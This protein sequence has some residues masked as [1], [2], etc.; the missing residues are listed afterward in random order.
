MTAKSSYEAKLSTFLLLAG[1]ILLANP[2]WGV[3]DLLPDLLAWV[4]IW[5]GLRSLSELNDELFLAR[6]QALYLMAIQLAK[7]LLWSPLQS[8]EIPSDTMLAV[9]VATVG[10]IWCGTLFFSRLFR[11]GDEISRAA[12][13]DALYLKT[14][15]VKFLSCMFLWVRGICTLLPQLTAIP[16]WLVQY[17]EI[18]DDDL[19]MLCMELAAATDLLNLLLS[20]FVIIA[21]VVWLVSYLPFLKKLMHE[22][23]PTGALSDSITAEDPIRLLKRRFS[24]LHMARIFFAIGLLFL[25]DLHVDGFRFMPLCGFPLCFA[26]G[27]L[28]LNGFGKEKRF[29][30]AAKLFA[31]GFVW[32]LLA[33]LYRRYF[34]IWDLRAFGEVDIATELI[35]A[36]IMLAGTC[37]LFYAWLVFSG[38]VEEL[39]ASVRCGNVYLG[40]ATY[41][42][43]V[44]YAAVQT[45]I[46][47]L[48]LAA[49]E[50]NSSRIL[51]VVLIW[52]FTNRRL[53]AFEEN[54][55]KQMMLYAGEEQ[56]E[57][58]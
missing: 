37:L 38:R 12:G 8:S 45:V 32:F 52:I 46:Y 26:V 27:C 4:M 19:Y 16:D 56:E 34:T 31:A 40:G 43:F 5:F 54:A 25:M 48:P 42:M 55:K 57:H 53:A 41:W 7:T 17:G 29:N 47:A 3:T 35:S 2:V 23:A 6:K 20:V 24:H 30:T 13:N 44:L 14:E 10:E 58:H 28:F 33:E 22:F 11:G 1:S 39:S 18:I 36:G 50:L 21:A 15:N 49:R 9:T 51:L